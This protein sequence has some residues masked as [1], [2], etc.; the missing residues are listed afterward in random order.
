MVKGKVVEV[1]GVEVTGVVE[2][3]VIHKNYEQLLYIGVQKDLLLQYYNYFVETVVFFYVDNI[4]QYFFDILYLG[5]HIHYHY[6]H[7]R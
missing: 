2:K 3:K 5:I 4:Y 1:T 6:I 7:C